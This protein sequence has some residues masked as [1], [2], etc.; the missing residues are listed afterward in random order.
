MPDKLQVSIIGLGLIG[1]SA[2]LALRRHTDR[3]TVVGHDPN[4][5]AAGTAKK[6]GAVD[7]TEWNLI[8][9]ISGADRVL[10]ALPL[11]QV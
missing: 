11:D 4:P 9:A 7:R 10:L 5:T 3:V 1:A 6:A 2:G 8:N